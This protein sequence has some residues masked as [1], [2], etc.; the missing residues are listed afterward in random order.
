[1]PPVFQGSAIL[2]DGAAIN[3]LPIDLMQRD[4][5]GF[6]IGSDASAISP[7][8]RTGSASGDPPFWRFFNRTRAGKP[9][10]N[11]FRLL[12]ESSMVGGESTA[13]AQ[14]EH[15]DLILRPPLLDVELLDWQSF[16]RIID[17]GYRHA[18]MAIGDAAAIPR[19]P[20]AMPK[21]YGG[22][23]S[24]RAEIERRRAATETRPRPDGLAAG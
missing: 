5:P 15:A 1:M 8:R 12:M 24:L 9:R 23:A 20:A 2:V 17:A 18:Q 6:V 16:E 10:L 14:R 7:L 19:L 21:T 13:A 4:A 22:G 11:I 3:N